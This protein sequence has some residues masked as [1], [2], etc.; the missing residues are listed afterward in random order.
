MQCRVRAQEILVL[1]AMSRA[2]WSGWTCKRCG[3]VGNLFTR[4]NCKHC[5]A[6]C[7][8][9]V[10]HKIRGEEEEQ[11][12]WQGHSGGGGGRGKGKGG[13]SLAASRPSRWNRWNRSSWTWPRGIGSRGP[14][15]GGKGSSA[16]G[17]GM[18]E[19]FLTRELA[20]K[21]VGLPAL[22]SQQDP[23]PKLA[24]RQART[25]ALPLTP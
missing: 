3:Q 19:R 15:G 14:K 21:V 22:T 25:K 16:Q 9:W 24:E 12:E 11:W 2:G 1:S 4:A 20:A 7:P 10:F 13:A 18:R 17:S 6:L 8:D 23:T 5:W